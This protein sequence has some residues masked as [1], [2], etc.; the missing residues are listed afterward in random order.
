MESSHL[1][2]PVVVEADAGSPL[3][4]HI[5]GKNAILALGKPLAH[6]RGRDAVLLRLTELASLGVEERRRGAR[7]QDQR[8]QGKK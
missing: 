1:H 5:V 4:V 3:R 6:D 7:G 8:G 2:A